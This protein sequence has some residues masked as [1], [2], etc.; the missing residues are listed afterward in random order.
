MNSNLW[1]ETFHPLSLTTFCALETAFLSRKKITFYLV[2][3]G[4]LPLIVHV[5]LLVISYR[6]MVSSIC[7]PF[8][9]LYVTTAFSHN[10]SIKNSLSLNKASVGWYVR[11]KFGY[12]VMP[13]MWRRL[14]RCTKML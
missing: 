14:V 2:C 9:L 7:L 13:R 10:T 3:G 4:K 1:N 12:K 11:Q 6:L 8:E 5:S